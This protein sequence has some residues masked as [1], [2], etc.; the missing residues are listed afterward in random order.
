MAVYTF[1]TQDQRRPTDKELVEA[2]KQHCDKHKLNF[3]LVVIDLL[4]KFHEEE[5]KHGR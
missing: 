3:S 5:V 2:V 4:R 1:S